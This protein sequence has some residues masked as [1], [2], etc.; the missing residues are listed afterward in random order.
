MQIID[1]KL[2]SAKVLEGLKEKV[3]ALREKHGVTPG[4]A[5][6]IVGDD[7]GSQVYVR[8]KVR[9]ATEL[10]MHSVKHELPKDTPQ[11]E[12]LALVNRLNRD[13]AI[14]GLLVQSPTPPQVDERAV[15]DAILPSKD[16]DCFHPYN[17]GRLFIGDEDGFMP[18]TPQGI[19]TLLAH[20][21]IETSGKHAVIIGRSNIVGKPLS[22]LLSRKSARADCTVTLC[23]SRTRE[24]GGICRQADILVAAIGKPRFVTVDM[25]KDGAVVIDV[26][27]NRVED[28]SKKSGYRL[29]GDVDF[30]AVSPKTSFI[31]PVP[32][33]VGPMTIAMLLTN[34]LRACLAQK[35]IALQAA[36]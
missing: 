11:S 12:V 25:V 35:G 13:D 5:V 18:C 32:G 29:V 2:V 34:A 4:L 17:V 26:G 22:V 19:M 30:E 23:H 31:T 8:N 6:V 28:A 3:A 9:T 24:L 14:H 15:V 20:Y 7:P 27:M 16:V 36:D 33:G 21:S 1:G 10:G